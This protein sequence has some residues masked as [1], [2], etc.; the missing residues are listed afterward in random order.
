[1]YHSHQPR[2]EGCSLGE[3]A[4]NPTISGHRP[5][6]QR[7]P[8][9]K[10]VEV[11]ISELAVGLGLHGNGQCQG[12]LSRAPPTPV[13]MSICKLHCFDSFVHQW[14]SPS[15]QP[16]VPNL[17]WNPSRLPVPLT[18]R[19][20]TKAVTHC[21]LYNIILCPIRKNINEIKVV[22]VMMESI[23]YFGILFII[24]VGMPRTMTWLSV[25]LNS[26]SKPQ[27][28]KECPAQLKTEQKPLCCSNF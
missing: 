10:E 15:S 23:K 18:W 2:V 24:L 11:F 19:H 1:M 16:F 21:T 9:I 3:R 8:S 7:K 13:T 27:N 6:Q 4:L 12:D 17:T 22:H 25:T 28:R 5:W 14:L 26:N 20:L